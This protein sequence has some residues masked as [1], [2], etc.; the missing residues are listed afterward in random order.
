[1][2]DNGAL[3]FGTPWGFGILTHQIDKWLEF[4]CDCVTIKLYKNYG[5]LKPSGTLSWKYKTQ[6][7]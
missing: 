2:Y 4:M 1:M 7:Q 6:F 3:C 5:L